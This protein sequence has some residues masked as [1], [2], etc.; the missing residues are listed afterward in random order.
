MNRASAALFLGASAM[1][2]NMY[3][4]QA[5]LPDVKRGLHVSAAVAG[6]SI[7]VVV[8]GVA[9]GGWVHGPLS[10]RTGRARV[11]VASAGLIVVPTALVAL[12]PNAAAFLALR[13]V[14]GLLMPGLLVVAV[15]YVSE[16]FRGRAAGVAMGAYTSSLVFGGLVGRVGTALIAGV[17]GWR[18]G[19]LAL[20][21]PTALGAVAMAA[22]LPRDPPPPARRRLGHAIA[23]HL[24]NLPLVV[25]ATG[26]GLTFFG[27]VG[28]FT[29]AT[30]RLTG[31]PLGLSLGRAG[32]VYGVWLVGAFTPLVGGLAHRAGPSR[33]LPPLAVAAACGAG[34]T[35]VDRLWVVI[36]GL[37]LMAAAMFFTV[38]AAQLLIPRLT[39]HARGTATSLHLTIYYVLGGAGAYLPG[40]VLGSGWG[41]VVAVCA[42][43]LGLAVVCA[44]AVGWAAPRRTREP[45]PEG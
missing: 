14:Q 17:A 8:L 9:A 27:F 44:L 2:A 23:G 40:L 12:A 31:P 36:A 32:L 26:A 43:A 25:N 13:L 39:G 15:P 35:L 10:D 3:S 11:M 29:Y 42:G 28:V 20:T 38:T 45:L 22:W 4:T 18:I 16:R 19:L 1:F 5:I 33:L 6:L 24:R 7:T 34:M 30:Y 41:A 37:A 21:V